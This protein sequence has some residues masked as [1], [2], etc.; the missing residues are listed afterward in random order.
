MG[1]MLLPASLLFGWIYEHASAAAAFGFSA[2]C[3]AGAAG[4]LW[5]G[6]GKG[7]SH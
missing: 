3:A 4:L 5:A 2:S 6:R 1:L 7:L